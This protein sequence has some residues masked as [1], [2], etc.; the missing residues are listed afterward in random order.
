M[1]NLVKV[2]VRFP[3]ESFYEKLIIDINKF[4]ISNE[5]EQ[6]VFGWYENIYI[7]I[8]KDSLPT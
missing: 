4:K 5:F 7:S 2:F 6:E 1:S 3:N 8:K